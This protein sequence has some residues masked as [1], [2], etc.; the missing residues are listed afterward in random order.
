MKM[1]VSSIGCGGENKFEN[2]EYESEELDSDDPD[3]SDDEKGPKVERDIE[4]VICTRGINGK[5]VWNLIPL[6][7]LGRPYVTNMH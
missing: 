2:N 3:A 7:T 5:L 6:K 4:R 1:V